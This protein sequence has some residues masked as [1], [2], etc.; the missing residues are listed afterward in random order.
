MTAGFRPFG[1]GTERDRGFVPSEAVLVA[2]VLSPFIALP[3]A[4]WLGARGVRH[5]QLL[6]LLPGSLTA[7]F[8]YLLGVVSTKGPFTTIVPWAPGLQLSLSFHFDGLSLVFAT[9][10]AGVGTLI[11]IYAA[12]YLEG[13]PQA[14]RFH[15][16]L[17]AFMGSMLG[18]VLS[19]NLIC[20]FVFWELT[21]FTSFILIGFDHERQDARRAATQ[22]FLVTGGGGLALLAAA[23]LLIRAGGTASISALIHSGSLANHPLYPGIAALVLLAAFTKSAQFPFHFWLPN[24]MEA[25]TPISAYLHSATMVKAGIYLVARF[26]PIF[27]GHTEWFWL[28]SGIGIVTMLYGSLNAVKQTDLKA[29]LAYSTISQLGLIMSLLG[30]GSASMY[31]ELGDESTIYAVA[32]FAAIFHLIN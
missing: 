8:I 16:A 11:V 5:A 6:A 17:F 23:I 18:V 3:V 24:A 14:G 10:I 13:H 22:A 27:G 1:S 32:V 28:V 31:F 29:L 7:Y 20:L 26:T 21:G 12:K 19:D 15:I 30:L 4:G 9:L 2:L 25:P